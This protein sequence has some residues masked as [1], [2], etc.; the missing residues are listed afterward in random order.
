MLKNLS[1]KNLAI[2]NNID[3]DFDVGLNIFTGETGAGKSIMLKALSFIMGARCSKSVVRSGEK[4]AIIEAI[5]ENL[6]ETIF[7]IFNEMKIKIEN[8]SVIVKRIIF[9]DG[10]STAFINGSMVSVTDLKRVGRELLIFNEQG[11]SQ[12]FL[13]SENNIY[14]LDSF[15]GIN[16]LVLKYRNE[17]VKL[18]EVLRK[19]KKL[20]NL[21]NFRNDKTEEL[22]LKISEIEKL[23]L[24][25][26]EEK[27]IGEKLKIIKNSAE[28]FEILN[29]IYDLFC[30]NGEFEGILNKIKNS[31]KQLEKISGF[32]EEFKLVYEKF[33]SLTFELEEAVFDV[34]N[35]K[36]SV[37]YEPKQLDYL[38]NR[39]SDI[40]K[41]KRKFGPTFNDVK[42]RLNLMKL[43]LEK[44]QNCE[45]QKQNLIKIRNEKLARLKQ[46][47][48]D[49]SKHRQDSA[50]KFSNAILNELKFLEMNNAKFIVELQKHK[51]N[52]NGLEDVAFL[53]S[54][55]QGEPLQPL[56]KVASGGEL[57][58]LLLA[59]VVVMLNK[60]HVPTIVF[61]EVDSGVS[62]IAAKKIGEKLKQISKN[63]Q[64][65]CIT[66]LAQIASV[67][68][69]HFKIFKSVDSNGRTSSKVLNLNFEEK[70]KE[71]ARLI[72][73]SETDELVVKLAAEMIKQN[74]N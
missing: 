72:G 58:R 64:I 5:F 17:F 70:T 49:I 38:E 19:L 18:N 15:A 41:I 3:I 54:T 59:F 39:L 11:S 14:F 57:S 63:T 26:D 7:K 61:D 46:Q 43:E 10:K 67:A 56:N 27:K 44:L 28:I 71:I 51:A 73:G 55:N 66:H 62:G 74:K 68:D 4:C 60:F 53:I 21:I 36:N 34:E 20:E 8:N 23:N 2:I 52:L 37:N 1:V 30:G 65:I 12:N 24:K 47:L 42:N 69:K 25:F 32:G 9:C 40:L 6:N 35:L 48:F 22:K 50:N 45:F 13:N 31:I 16:E 33:K 29:L